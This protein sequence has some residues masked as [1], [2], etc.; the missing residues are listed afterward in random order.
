M[1]VKIT[2]T[3]ESNTTEGI[4]ILQAIKKQILSGEFQREFQDY[5]SSNIKVKTEFEYIE[6]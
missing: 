5:K 4:E 2:F 3:A 6:K 1:K